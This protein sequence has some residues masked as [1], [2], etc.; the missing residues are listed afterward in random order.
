[1]SPLKDVHSTEHWSRCTLLSLGLL[2][3]EQSRSVSGIQPTA[4]KKPYINQK[5]L[6][7]L[8]PKFYFQFSS[9]SF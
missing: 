1:M 9:R 3:Q 6:D 7:L 8:G 4:K 2:S 5:P